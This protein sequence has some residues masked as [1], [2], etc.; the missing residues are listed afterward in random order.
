MNHDTEQP[1]ESSYVK[2]S[3]VL[4]HLGQAIQI[5]GIALEKLS[6]APHDLESIQSLE[7]ISTALEGIA[8]CV[9]K[10]AQEAREQITLN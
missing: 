4:H 6:N 3:E 7:Q 1:H 10:L 8:C 5:N 2:Y 9:K